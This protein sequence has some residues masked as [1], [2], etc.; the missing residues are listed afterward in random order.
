MNH[1]EIIKRFSNINCARLGD[2]Y[3]PHKP[4][5]VLLVLQKILMGHENKF[6]FS[7]LDHDLKNDLKNMVL[8]TLQ[9]RETNLSGA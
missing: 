8:I 7:E 4:I 9:T 2:G 3:A 5:L 6:S 1:A